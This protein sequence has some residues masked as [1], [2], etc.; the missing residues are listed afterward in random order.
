M[1]DGE[2]RTELL[3]EVKGRRSITPAGSWEEMEQRA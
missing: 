3:A 1:S 2:P